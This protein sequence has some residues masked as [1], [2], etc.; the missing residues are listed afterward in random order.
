MTRC[1]TP[2]T[3]T[4]AASTSSWRTTTRWASTATQWPRAQTASGAGTEAENI[5]NTK[6]YLVTNLYFDC[7]LGYSSGLHVWEFTWPQRQHGTHAVVG[8]A[9]RLENIWQAR[10]YYTW[11]S[12]LGRLRCTQRATPAWWA[13]TSTAGAGTWAAAGLST[14]PRRSPAD[15]IQVGF[16]S[17]SNIFHKIYK[18]FFKEKQIFL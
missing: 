15:S 14:T 3:L 8:V 2:G 10:K 5:Y 17:A 7:R 18:Y 11:L 6:K 12:A 9:T 13:A 4:T 1:A 16:S